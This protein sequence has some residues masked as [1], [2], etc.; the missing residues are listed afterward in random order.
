[1]PEIS[2]PHYRIKKD[3]LLPFGFV[4]EEEGFCYQTAIL[5]G[6]FI[7]SVRLDTKDRVFADLTD[8][9]TGAPYVLHLVPEAVGAFVG[10]VRE[11]YTS[12]LSK[13]RDGCFYRRV[14][15]NDTVYRLLDY[16]KEAYG[17][18]PEYL[19]EKFPENAVLR[20]KD[21]GTW[22]GA[23]LTTSADRLG[24]SSQEKVE[25]LDFRAIPETIPDL[26]KNAGFFPGWHMNKKHWVTLLLDG[27]IPLE[28]IKTRLDESYRL[29][30]K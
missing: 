23:V 13:I 24:L 19:W 4:P 7:L 15:Q 9:S 17:S 30:K 12:A 28:E 8:A 11:A 14:F 2:F 25:I 27:S 5:S 20:R 3:A 29:A 1:M 21:T 16:A 22:Y 26:L 10:E 6:Q 18:E